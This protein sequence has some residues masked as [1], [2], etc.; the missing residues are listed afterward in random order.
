MSEADNIFPIKLPC[1]PLGWSS[2]SLQPYFLRA[3]PAD[4]TWYSY[5]T[6]IHS[7]SSVEFVVYDMADNTYGG[8][9]KSIASFK[10]DVP[11]NATAEAIDR[12]I[13]TLARARREAELRAAEEEI[14]NSYAAGI[15]ASLAVSPPEGKSP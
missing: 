4:L 2:Y 13:V 15:R 6:I 7:Q 12:R 9:G 11:V 1:D 8:V 3:T 5:D 10:A 14:I